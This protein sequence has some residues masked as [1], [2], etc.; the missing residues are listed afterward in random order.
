MKDEAPNGDAAAADEDQPE[1]SSS[2]ETTNGSSEHTSAAEE[3]SDSSEAKPAEE[4]DANKANE[5]VAQEAS[6]SGSN[7]EEFVMVP[8]EISYVDEDGNHVAKSYYP[9][10]QAISSTINGFE[11]LIT[12]DPDNAGLPIVVST[13]SDVLV[14]PIR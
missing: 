10:N 5:S 11:V 1:A 7:E 8:E 14:L 2:T 13:C 12:F 9:L 3:G 6:K 4:S